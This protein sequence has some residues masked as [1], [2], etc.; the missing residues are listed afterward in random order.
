M[1]QY[2]NCYECMDVEKIFNAFQIGFSDYM[3]QLKINQEDFMQRFFGPEGN[4]LEHSFIA[5]DGEEPVGLILGGIKN[6]DGLKTMRC[7]ALCIHPDYRG[8]GISKELFKLHKELALVKDCKQMFLEVIVGNDRAIKFY[9]NLGYN[10]IYDLS[11]FS[12]SDVLKLQTEIDSRFKVHKIDFHTI[13]H[14]ANCMKDIHIN[15]QNDL[16]YMSKL[17]SLNHY[18]VYEEEQLIGALSISS[19]G[20]LM[21]I[22]TNPDYRNRGIGKALVGNAVRD[23]NISKVSISF[24]NNASI[25]GFVKH[26]GFKRDEIAQYEMYL[27][28]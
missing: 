12:C 5:L 11:Y 27:T 14:L 18:S 20:K 22:Y 26:I 23:L 8:K 15:W 24:P 19:N 7:G 1:I 9:K 13:E 25:E 16:D 21:F 28:L 4:Q 17:E 3:I 10:K 6:F 2:R